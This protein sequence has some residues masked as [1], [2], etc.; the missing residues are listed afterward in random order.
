MQ[1]KTGTSCGIPKKQLSGAL[2][3]QSSILTASSS[4]YSAGSTGSSIN[5]VTSVGDPTASNSAPGSKQSTVALGLSQQ[6]SMLAAAVRAG[7]LTTAGQDTSLSCTMAESSTEL[8]HGQALQ[9]STGLLSSTGHQ[10]STDTSLSSTALQSNEPF[11]SDGTTQLP[12][13]SDEAALLHS[14]WIR[15]RVNLLL[16]HAALMM[17]VRSSSRPGSMHMHFS[18]GQHAIMLFAY[19]EA[20]HR[21]FERR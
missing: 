3:S 1:K 8:Q 7:M 15:Q 16:L 19:C 4:F 12:V 13:A 9:E 11:S 5:K 21:L 14:S 20:H 10:S 2:T 17:P 18:G 6:S